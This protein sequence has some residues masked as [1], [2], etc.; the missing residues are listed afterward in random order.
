MLTTHTYDHDCDTDCNV[1]GVTRTTTHQYKTTWS[2]DGNN[3]WHE[4]AVCKD[5]KD[6]KA[7]A[8]G[9]AATEYTAQTCTEC[10]YV[11]MAALGHTHTYATTWT[12]DEEGHWYKCAGCEEKG[13]YAEH[14][15]ENAC[16]PDCSI[17]EY[18]R[19]V[20]HDFENEW[21]TDEINHWH[22]CS[23]CGIKQDEAAHEPGAEATATTAQTCTIC[24]YEIA[25]ALGEE[26][27]EPEVEEPETT[28]PTTTEPTE[29]ADN[30]GAFPLWIV[31]VSVVGVAA[32]AAAVIVIIKKKR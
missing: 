26:E 25:P 19:E 22:E 14:D 30:E 12:T 10:G 3:H 13:S 1:C 31:V 18:T 29:P 17:C 6:V 32:V 5:K 11:I 23:G 8:P 16:D 21:T 20:K 15:F 24:E 27:P 28:A 7:H 9:A 2:A 4:C